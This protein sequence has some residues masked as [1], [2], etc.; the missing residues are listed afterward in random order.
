MLQHEGKTWDFFLFWLGFHVKQE[1]QQPK[2]QTYK[3]KEMMKK[4]GLKPKLEDKEEVKAEKISEQVEE[5][6]KPKLFSASLKGKY[7]LFEEQK[8][9]LQ[10]IVPA[11]DFDK[12]KTEETKDG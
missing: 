7:S 3:G 2:R 11:E 4:L 12:M 5:D 8:Q 10:P 9:L 6:R 1:D